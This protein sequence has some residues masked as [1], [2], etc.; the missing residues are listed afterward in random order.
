MAL[1]LGEP[2]DGSWEADARRLLQLL[3]NWRYA[4]LTGASARP[5][6]FTFTIHTFDLY[7]GSPNPLIA[8]ERDVLPQV[9]MK[10]R[11]DLDALA[12]MVDDLA[13][14][15]TWRGVSADGE[16]IA[17]WILPRDLAD[18]GSG[19]SY[20]IGGEPPPTGLDE[21]AYPY[22][23]VVAERLA[24]THLACAGSTD[25][26]DVYGFL[27][28]TGGWSWGL[29]QTGFSCSDGRA[30]EWVY[31]VVPEG[32]AC[33]PAPAGVTGAA[34]VDAESWPASEWCSLAEIA[35]PP[36]G[37]IVEATGGGGFADACSPL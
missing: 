16:S 28:C 35:V 26:A 20:E 10:Y 23:Y 32:P 3:V 31:L 21:D 13:G 12:R 25:D 8:D 17:R 30:A 34:A 22:L 1:H 27:R 24:R 33:L 7:P 5:W 4:S 15:A 18:D 19:F 37:S 14:R 11:G 9:G 6:T 36:Q 2:T 29:R